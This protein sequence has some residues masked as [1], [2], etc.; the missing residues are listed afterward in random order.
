MAGEPEFPG[1]HYDIGRARAIAATLRAVLDQA[2][3]ID[4]ERVDLL[5]ATGILAAELIR[6][7]R[8]RTAPE[9]AAR[10]LQAFTVAWIAMLSEEGRPRT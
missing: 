5:A 3:L 10:Q 8:L 6:A 4:V 7:G 2:R 9:Y 1:F